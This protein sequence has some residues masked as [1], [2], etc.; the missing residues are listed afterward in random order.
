MFQINDQAMKLSCT[1]SDL[2]IAW[3]KANYKPREFVRVILDA[4]YSD[5]DL[6][7]IATSTNLHATNPVIPTAIIGKV[8]ITCVAV[9]VEFT[10]LVSLY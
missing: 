9:Y 6:V 7:K 2:D 8:Y 4:I 5:D 3:A 10:M 1:A